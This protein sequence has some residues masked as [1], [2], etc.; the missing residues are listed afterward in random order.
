MKYYN[1]EYV[2]GEEILSK[3]FKPICNNKP[4]SVKKLELIRDFV[5]KYAIAQEILVNEDFCE[6]DKD[7]LEYDYEIYSLTINID[8]NTKLENASFFKK[9][10]EKL[11]LM[12][13][14][15]VKNENDILTLYF[16][17][18]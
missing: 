16:E 9:I 15:I 10:F 5:N 1:N 3:G 7:D 12:R 6:D 14:E 11:T 17:S 18:E 2:N 8:M 4:F 13:G